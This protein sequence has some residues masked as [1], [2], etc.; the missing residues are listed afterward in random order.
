MDILQIIAEKQHIKLLQKRSIFLGAIKEGLDPDDIYQECA[1]ELWKCSLSEKSKYN[2]ARA[3]PSTYI[4]MVCSCC[5]IKMLRKA[6]RLN[7]IPRN[8][9]VELSG[10]EESYVESGMDD[11]LSELVTDYLAEFPGTSPDKLFDILLDME[12]INS[13]DPV[14]KWLHGK[15]KG[16]TK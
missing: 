6:N 7:V 9:F 16:E 4:G 15:L 3:K 11:Y 12:K 2:P 8:S 5:I 10:D 1:I 14:S 13:V